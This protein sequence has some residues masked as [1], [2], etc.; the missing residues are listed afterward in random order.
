MADSN[1]KTSMKIDAKVHKRF[2]YIELD[3]DKSNISEAMA[4]VL[5]FYEK[6]HKNSKK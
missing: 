1:N 6:H 4:H 5:D 3:A 2:K